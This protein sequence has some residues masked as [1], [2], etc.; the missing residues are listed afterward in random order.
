MNYMVTKTIACPTNVKGVPVTLEAV[1]PDG[2]R[3]PIGTVTSDMGGLFK[4][5]WTPPVEGEYTI[6]ATFAGSKSYG[7][8]FAETAIGVTAA[9]PASPSP[10]ASPSASVSPTPSATASA[11]P[12]APP[13]GSAP[14][15]NI[16]VITAIIVAVAAVLVAA[17]VVLKRRH[18]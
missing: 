15:I 18:R 5:L 12:S 10:S 13:A 2:T 8:S 17:A 3:I 11:S 7:P 16:Y 4:K 14:G 6:I 1:A 9:P